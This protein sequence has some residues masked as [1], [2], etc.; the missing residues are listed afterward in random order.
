MLSSSQNDHSPQDERHRYE[1]LLEMADLVVRHLSLPELF[2][3]IA[4]RLRQVADFQFLNFSLHDARDNSMHALWWEGPYTEELPTT[5]PAAESPSGWVR[6]RQ[7]ELLFSDVKG[8]TRFPL[9]LDPLRKRGVQTY[10]VVPLTA[11]QTRLGALGVASSEPDAYKEGDKRLLRRVGELVALAVENTMTREALQGEKL[12]LRALVEVNRTLASSLEM[13]R[14]LPLISECVT[15]VVPHDFAGVTLFEGDQKNMKAYVLSPTPTNPLAEMGRSVSIEQTL[16][17]KALLQKESHTMTREDLINHSSSI[18]DRIVNAGIRTVRCMPLLTSKGSLGT[19]NVGSKKD[20]AFSVQDEEI[21]NQIAAQLAIAL[22]NARAYREIQEL[23]ERLAEE[24][25]YLQDEI[26]T[27]LHFEEI[28]GESA[29]LMAALSQ[30]KTVA[31]SSSTVLILGETGTGK[32]LAARAIHRMSRRKDANFIKVNCAAIPTG[33]LES[34][35]FGHEKGAFTGAVSKKVGRLELADKGTFFLD[36]IGDIP[37]ELQPKLLRVLQDQEFE[38][39]GSNRTIRVDLRL[40]AATNR[41]L[42]KRVAEGQFREDLFYR[43]NVFPIL[44]P[45]LRQRPRDIPLLVRYFV[46]KI[47]RRH[48]KKIETIPSGTMDALVRWDWPGNVRELENFIERSVI[49]S[50]GSV[51]RA[52]MSELEPGSAEDVPADATLVSAERE[53]IAR[54][55]RECGGV[56]SGPRGAAEKLGLKRTT[57]Q[58]KMR[59]LGIS[60]QGPDC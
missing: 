58:S 8:E 9:V 1:V 43:L 2:R 39:L 53:H 56:I 17:A 37:L 59:K 41:D 27:E 4:T 25:L 31:P 57:L 24:K 21:L 30:V 18:S 16:S 51:L 14:L 49:L 19:L 38:R 32:E 10:Y 28:I 48:D 47:A 12:R 60:R 36:E 5:I 22:D 46:Q 6:E 35:L 44:M 55:L 23:K 11:A 45:P 13:Q 26:R 50:S 33:L 34:E 40:V 3:D 15:R 20:A 54:V 52:P 29:E 7:E 42:R